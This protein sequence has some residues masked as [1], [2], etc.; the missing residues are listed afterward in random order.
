MS[1]RGA[2][3]PAGNQFLLHCASETL[4]QSSSGNEFRPLFLLLLDML[5]HA[6]EYRLC[7]LA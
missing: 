2:N 4:I 7:N 5:I 1:M 3:A 6:L